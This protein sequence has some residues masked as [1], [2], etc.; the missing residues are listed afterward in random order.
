MITIITITIFTTLFSI[1]IA[2]CR[3]GKKKEKNSRRT[4]E[5][6]VA[7]PQ[8]IDLGDKKSKSVELSEKSNEQ[9]S[10]EENK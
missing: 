9:L 4:I 5:I 1:S 7:N 8:I 10:V 6:K 3:N 2:K